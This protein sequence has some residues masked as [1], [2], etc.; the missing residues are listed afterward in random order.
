MASPGWCLVKVSLSVAYLVAYPLHL[1]C[2]LSLRASDSLAVPRIFCFPTTYK[3]PYSRVLVAYFAL[4][5]IEPWL[6]GACSV[7]IWIQFTVPGYP[8]H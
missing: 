5:L 7:N 2:P 6:T 3:C 4:V 1:S 8:Y